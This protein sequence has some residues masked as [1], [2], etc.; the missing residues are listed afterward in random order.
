MLVNKG[1]DDCLNLRIMSLF[2]CKN[3]LLKMTSDDPCWVIYQL[4]AQLNLVIGW[5]KLTFSIVR[6]S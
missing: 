5:E 3:D 6:F 4:S 1:F 2:Y